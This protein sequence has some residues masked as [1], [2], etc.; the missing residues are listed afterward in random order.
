MQESRLIAEVSDM[1]VRGAFGGVRQQQ[2]GSLV[3]GMDMDMDVD[4]ARSMWMMTQSLFV[5][6]NG[7]RGFVDPYGMRRWFGTSVARNGQ[8]AWW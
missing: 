4:M 5:E 2:L 6:R 8:G 3:M 7:D 1:Y